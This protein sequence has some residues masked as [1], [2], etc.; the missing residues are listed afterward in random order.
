MKTYARIQ[1]GTVAELLRTDMPIA[2]L[3][4]PGLTWVDVSDQPGVAEGWS[5]NGTRFEKPIIPATPAGLPTMAQVLADL[6]SLNAEI[7]ALKAQ[8][9]HPA[10]RA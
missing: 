9:V 2:A 10:N 1:D 6:A 7:A 3:F 5:F 8:V 4:H